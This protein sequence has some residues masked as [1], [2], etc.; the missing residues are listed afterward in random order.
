MR[1]GASPQI[2]ADEKKPPAP[3]GVT[4]GIGQAAIPAD[5]FQTAQARFNVKRGERCPPAQNS[6]RFSARLAFA[7][8]GRCA[9]P[10]IHSEWNRPKEV[11]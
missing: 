3:A 11:V 8:G 2:I 1:M 7:F 9:L 4:T 10:A 5:C 6:P